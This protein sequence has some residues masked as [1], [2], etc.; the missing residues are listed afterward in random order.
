MPLGVRHAPLDDVEPGL[1]PAC[2][3]LSPDG[4]LLALGEFKAQAFVICSVVLIDWE[5]KA[6][7]RR[8][9]FPP[10]LKFQARTK[11]QD[12]A[13]HIAFSPDG[14]RL[15]VGTRSGLIHLWNLGRPQAEGRPLSWQAHDDGVVGLAFGVDSASVYSCAGDRTLTRWRVDGSGSSTR[16]R[17]GAV[18]HAERPTRNLAFHRAGG[19]ACLL[20]DRLQLLDPETLTVR[21]STGVAQGSRVAWSPDGRLLAVG[22]RESIAVVAAETGLVI[23][24]IVDPAIAAAHKS[25]PSDL[26]FHPSGSVLASSGSHD[27]DRRVKLWDVVSGG[28]M[29]TYY[30]GGAVDSIINGA[31]HPGGR[32]LVITGRDRVAVRELA[33]HPASGTIASQ[34]AYVEGLGFSPD[35]GTLASV[36]QSSTYVRVGVWDV[37]TG[38]CR[39]LSRI[40]RDRPGGEGEPSV[41]VDPSGGNLA[42]NGA[43]PGVYLWE[44]GSTSAP[45]LIEAA[46][47]GWLRFSHDGHRLWGRFTSNNS[48][49]VWDVGRREFASNWSDLLANPLRG[50]ASVYCVTAA[51]PWVAV[52]GRDGFTKLLRYADRSLTWVASWGSSLWPSAKPVPE[53]RRPVGRLRDSAGRG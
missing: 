31:F 24:A 21:R 42:F 2:Q 28:L 6:V 51:E 29:T 43:G 40:P 22:S 39:A 10:S 50:L 47:P 23:R 49:G 3:A 18:L 48:V 5:T 44:S 17:Q 7:V 9:R 15:V 16:A 25:P 13:R 52:G 27:E 30:D 38:A 36:G 19:L 37:R 8:L 33:G 46:A 34:D 20:D 32:H 14:R 41:A 12:G 4:R 45:V 26:Q 1:N 11:V 35:G 53:P